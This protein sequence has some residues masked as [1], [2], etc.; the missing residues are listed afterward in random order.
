MLRSE[1]KKSGRVLMR[2]N[3]CTS[4]C[5][6]VECNASSNSVTGPQYRPLSV[7]ENY[8]NAA[9][10]AKRFAANASHDDKAACVAMGTRGHVM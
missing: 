9:K 10:G 3:N 4:G 6:A 8:S 2:D 5:V 1:R 7:V